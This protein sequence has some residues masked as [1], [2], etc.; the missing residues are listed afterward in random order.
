MKFMMI[1]KANQDSEAG[2]RPSAELLAARRKYTEE[3]VSAGILLAGDG[4]HPSA[5]GARVKFVGDQRLVTDG[6]FIE[7]KELIAGYWL[8]QMNSLAEAIEW[9]KRAPNP[10][11]GEGEIEIRQVYEPEDYGAQ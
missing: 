8:G 7:T 11:G 1:V 5:K 6:P 9:V 10:T 3:L 2:V 4:L